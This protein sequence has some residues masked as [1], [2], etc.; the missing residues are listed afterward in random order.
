MLVN[1]S[2]FGKLHSKKLNIQS[3]QLQFNPDWDED[4]ILSLFDLFGN[5][6]GWT[7]PKIPKITNCIKG[8]RNKKPIH[9]IRQYGLSKFLLDNSV[10]SYAIPSPRIFNYTAFKKIKKSHILDQS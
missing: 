10:F 1:I 5:N 4:I 8:I 9:E 3:K 6:L 2:S 7:P